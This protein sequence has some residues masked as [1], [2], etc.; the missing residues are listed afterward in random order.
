MKRILILISPLALLLLSGCLTAPVP[1]RPS[2]ELDHSFLFLPPVADKTDKRINQLGAFCRSEAS[3]ICRNGVRYASDVKLLQDVLVAPNLFPSGRLNRDEVLGLAHA[4]DC[5]S[6]GVVRVLEYQ[7]LPPQRIMMR[8][9]WIRAKDG[10]NYVNKTIDLS[11]ANPYTKEDFRRYITR[12]P[13]ETSLYERFAGKKLDF[14]ADTAQLSPESFLRYAAATAMS[15]LLDAK[16]AVYSAEMARKKAKADAAKRKADAI[17]REQKMQERLIAANKAVEDLE[18]QVKALELKYA[19]EVK[20]VEIKAIENKRQG[21]TRAEA[22]K[23]AEAE[24]VRKAREESDK[25]KQVE[26]K[27]LLDKRRLEESRLEDTLASYTEV[28]FDYARNYRRRADYAQAESALGRALRLSPESAKL[29]Y[30]AGVL[31]YEQKNFTKAIQAFETALS[32]PDASY[33]PFA[34]IRI[35]LA[36]RHSSGSSER[37]AEYAK[38][39]RSNNWP[40]PVVNMLL[41]KITPDQC[42]EQTRHYRSETK[43]DRECSAHFYMG[44]Y[45]LLKGENHHA[46]VSFRKAAATPTEWDERDAAR[47]RLGIKLP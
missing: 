40:A 42:L 18:K 31:Y 30:F 28:Y 25:K 19:A 36:E 35:H 26:L 39:W 15:Q 10:A 32:K 29:H 34:Q 7:S 5:G 24:I 41:E 45:Y 3:A 44:E 43:K 20:R 38:E 23:K 21:P 8:V 17:V 14:Q 2:I 6:A 47:R 37:L 16:S 22:F 1:P 46:I 9:F 27:A 12:K 11:L 13:E 4:L 33:H